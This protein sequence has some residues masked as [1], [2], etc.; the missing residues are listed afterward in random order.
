V[1]YG[2]ATKSFGKKVNE[3]LD[4]SQDINSVY[5]LNDRL[6]N[7]S[8]KSTLVAKQIS[9]DN[10]LKRIEYLIKNGDPMDDELFNLA[11]DKL[12]NLYLRDA[13]TQQYLTDD[14]FF[15]ATD[16]QKKTYIEVGYSYNGYSY[17]FLT[18]EQKEW[19]RENRH[20]FD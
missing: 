1:I 18:D 11:S 20:L 17:S 15:Y 2:T 5:D 13:I 9:D 10:K 3:L 4:G 6:Y 19:F 12:K 16:E 7:D 14:Q 8:G